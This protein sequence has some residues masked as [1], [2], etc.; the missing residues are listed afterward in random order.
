[1]KADG[2]MLVQPSDDGSR[3]GYKEDYPNVYKNKQGNYVYRS[4]KGDNEIYRSG[5]KTQ[6]AASKWGKKEFVKKFA[7]PNKFVNAAELSEILDV[8]SKKGS[9]MAS[10]LFERADRPKYLLQEARKILGSYQ[11]GKNDFF[12]A[13]TKKEIA[14][15]KKYSQS[16]VIT[17]GLAKNVQIILNSK[18][19]MND[20]TGKNKGGAKLPDFNKMIQVF[21]KN[22]L[23]ISDAQIT[24]ALQKAAYILRGDVYQSDVK[25]DIDKNT[26]RFI[27]KELEKLPFDN[28]YARGIYKHALNEIRL[29]LG[30][31]A[32]NLESFKR[33]FRKKLPDGFLKKHN[34]NINEVFSVRASAN[35][36]S[37]PYAYFVDVI[38]AD[39]NKKDLRSFH[40][41]LSKAQKNLN[42]K[43]N[44]IRAGKGKY[45]EA[46]DIVN[47]FQET[48][49]KFKN[50]IETNYPNKN[51]NLADIVLGKESEIVKQNMKIPENVYSK[52]LLTKWADQGLDIAKDAKSRGFVMTGADSPTVYTAKDLSSMKFNIRTPEGRLNMKKLN[53]SVAFQKFLKEN[54]IV[55]SGCGRQKRVE[56]GRITFSNGT[57]GGFKN[58]DEFA[59]GDP[60]GFLNTVKA[61]PK[62]AQLINNADSGVMKNAFAWAANDIKK[63]TGWLGGDLAVS[64]V[65][66]ANALME[67]KTPLEALDQGLLWFLPNSVLDSYKKSLTE[68][69][70]EGEAIRIKKALDLEN[71]DKQYLTNEAE[72]KSL[73]TQIQQNPD[74]FKQVTAEQIQ[75][76]K[77]RLLTNIEEARVDG[78]RILSDLADRQGTTLPGTATTDKNTID[79][80]NTSMDDLF[81]AKKQ[82]AIK[83]SNVARQFD[84]GREYQKYL[85][86]LIMPD[87]IEEKLGKGNKNYQDFDILGDKSGLFTD[88]FPSLTRPFAP[89]TATIGQA[90]QGY[91]STNLPF[92]DKLQN[93]LENIAISRGK[94]NLTQ[95]ITMDNLTQ[96]DFDIANQYGEGLKRK[97]ASGG[98]ASLTK[99]IPPESGPTPHGL[100]YVYNNVKKI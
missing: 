51:F 47:K 58:A 2:G 19:I 90:A 37:F 63:P 20:L 46:V 86:D 42:D 94:E 65:F 8:G 68:G 43:I 49:G 26:G 57:C 97:Y 1:M 74:L 17:E 44:D 55:I 34:L 11:A 78:T 30:E 18:A 89:V 35:N 85:N 95:P 88:F 93:Y 29:E 72:L 39:L 92:A 84:I 77:N 53:T 22:G 66:S 61:D 27:V 7:L 31:T 56:G 25:F 50:T 40:G 73:E 75:N 4:G 59:K 70:S 6:E 38:D 41:A 24:N 32:G 5:F 28:Q 33:N 52:K 21:K 10:P 48:R 36:K 13:P 16:P 60:D 80:F 87:I 45:D 96:G 91:A 62:A 23:D 3:P 15:L 82:K 100:P 71:A 99:T 14:Y 54:G 69:M 98:I 64:T 9:G 83:D 12:R 76:S 79:A 67:G 81:T